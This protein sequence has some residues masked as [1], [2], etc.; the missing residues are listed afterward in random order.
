MK[1]ILYL[2]RTEADFERVV[3]LALEGKNSYKQDFIFTGDFSPFF[4]SGVKNKFQK[5]IFLENKFTVNDFYTYSKFL[6]FF[7]IFFKITKISINDV[8]VNKKLIFKYIFFRL[9]LNLQDKYKKNIIN[10]ILKKYSYDFLL[11]DQSSDEPTYIQSI[12]RDTALKFNIKIFTFTHGAAGGL[13]AH[14][15]NPHFLNYNNFTVFVCNKFETNTN[16][17]NRIILGDVSSSYPYTKYL[18]EIEFEKI[19]FQDEKMYKIGIMMG[20]IAELTSTTAW[21]RQEE[22]II[23]YGNNED[24]AIV[25]K[26]HPRETNFI[27]LRM[28]SQFSNVLI[29]NQEVDRSRVVKWA[30]IIICNDH[31]S[32]IFSPMILG[33][34]VVALRGKHIPIFEKMY[35]PLINSSVNYFDNNKKINLTELRFSDPY[36]K[37][38]NEICW[39]NHG[40]INLANQLFNKIEIC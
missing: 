40:P 25:L 3:C 29:V 18:D 17:K 34:K 36:D 7:V 26:L 30:D 27:D 22:F 16:L 38:L 33:K 21:K 14:F 6:N 31:C 12:F 9:F 11:T 24:V 35:S 19:Y 39:G 28:V 20:G 5:K 13:H 37:I 10:K 15:S 32:T 23:E 4:E 2:I 1:K 8:L